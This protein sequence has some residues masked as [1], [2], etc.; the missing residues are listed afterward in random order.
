LPTGAAASFSPAS[1][2]GAGSS[3]L[4]VTTTSA[5]PLGT[6]P[7]AISGRVLS[8]EGRAL[9]ATVTLSFAEARGYPAPP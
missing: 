9:A 6:Y 5:T 2:T 8:E 1:V 4:T 3:V 7:S